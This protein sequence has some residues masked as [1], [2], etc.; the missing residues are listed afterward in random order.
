MASTLAELKHLPQ[1]CFITAAAA[2]AL[3]AQEDLEKIREQALRDQIKRTLTERQESR[4]S[5]VSAEVVDILIC[6]SSECP[7]DGHCESTTDV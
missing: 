4:G 5:G 7:V 3:R 6:R 1:I 2:I